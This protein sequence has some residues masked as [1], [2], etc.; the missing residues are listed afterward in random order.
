MAGYNRDD[1]LSTLGLRDW[2]ERC[3]ASLIEK[4]NEQE[5]YPA[6]NVVSEALEAATISALCRIWDKTGEAGRIT[7]VEK[8]LRR[9]PDLAGDNG[10]RFG[11][12]TGGVEMV[13]KSEE[14]Q[15][16]RAVPKHAPR[17]T[18]DPNRSDPR[19]RSGTRKAV[20]EDELLLLEATILVVQQLH[21][22]IGSPDLWTIERKTRSLACSRGI[23]LERH[24][25]RAG[26][27]FVFK[28]SGMWAH[29]AAGHAVALLALRIPR[30]RAGIAA[31]GNCDGWV[32]AEPPKS[33]DELVRPARD[34]ALRVLK[35][36]RD[37]GVKR[38]VMTSSVAAVAYGL[39]A[40]A[41]PFSEA[42]WS[43]PADLTDTGPYERSKTLAERAAWA[44]LAAEGGRLELVTVNPSF[45]LGPI[46]G[47][48]FSVSLNVVKKLLDGSAPLVPRFNFDIVDVRDIARLH[49]LAMT[50]PAAASQRFIGAGE[51][52]WMKD[53]AVMLKRGLGEKG[54]KVPTLPAPDFAVRI[55]ALFDPVIRTRLFD[56]GV[57]RTVS[58]DKARRML[59]WTTRPV[60]ETVLEA[61]RSLQEQGIV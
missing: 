27:S 15:A 38:V 48:D 37:A 52:L 29:H 8:L 14:L 2:L 5:I 40:R 60:S 54:R 11:D 16:L 17:T 61:A 58:S 19:L 43:D 35:V 26:L 59:G 51:A 3:R 34:G 13:E 31:E 9:R 46:F 50:E 30:P 49:L 57:V 7:E 25:R 21:S 20:N 4:V 33:D 18:H 41:E 36:A 53:I 56:L 44:W 12:G 6:F 55:L 1:C 32:P 10:A 45:V 39:P 24:W 23:I 42:D 22:L 47:A 28:R